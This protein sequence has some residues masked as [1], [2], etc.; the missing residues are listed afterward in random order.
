MFDIPCPHGHGW[1]H[2]IFDMAAVLPMIG[3]TGYYMLK[4]QIYRVY[5][6]CAKK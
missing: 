6:R 5:N 1:W 2:L 4:S 3:L